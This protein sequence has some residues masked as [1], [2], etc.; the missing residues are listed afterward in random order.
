MFPSKRFAPQMQMQVVEAG[1]GRGGTKTGL[2]PARSLFVV[3]VD[4]DDLSYADSTLVNPVMPQEISLCLRSFFRVV[5]ILPNPTNWCFEQVFSSRSR[6]VIFKKS[7]S[8]NTYRPCRSCSAQASASR[9]TFKC[10]SIRESQLAFY[11]RANVSTKVQQKVFRKEGALVCCPINSVV[12]HHKKAC[13]WPS[14]C[15]HLRGH[16]EIGNVRHF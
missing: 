5:R 4:I 14:S 1:D 8:A 6:A 3:C 13:K 15:V 12:M 7:E 16:L 2:Q 9:K 10:V 11:E